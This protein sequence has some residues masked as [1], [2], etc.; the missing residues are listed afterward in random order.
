MHGEADKLFRAMPEKFADIW[1]IQKG[2][3]ETDALEWPDNLVEAKLKEVSGFE[4]KV[5]KLKKCLGAMVSVAAE[6]R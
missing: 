3:K 5:I 4:A 2:L 6:F 1:E